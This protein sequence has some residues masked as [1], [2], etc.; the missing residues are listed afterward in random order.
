MTYNP[1]ATAATPQIFQAIDNVTGLP[2][3]GGL[4]YTYAS[5]TLT[6]QA[7]YTDNT[8][9]VPMSNPIVLDNYGQAI[10]W[11]STSPYRFNLINAAGVQQAHYPMD[12]IQPANF[13]SFTTSLAGYANTSQGQGL[14]GFNAA[15]SYPTNT[16]PN[17]LAASTGSSLIGYKSTLSNSVL[18]TQA[19]KDSDWISVLDFGADPTGVTDSTTSIQ[20][21]LN[22]GGNIYVPAG[23]YKVGP[24]TM[25]VAGTT[26][27][28]AGNGITIFNSTKAIPFAITASLTGTQLSVSSASG[29]LVAGMSVQPILTASVQWD[30]T[31]I[32]S[33]TNGGVAPCVATLASSPGNTA[34]ESMGCYPASGAPCIWIQA[35]NCSVRDIQ[36]SFINTPSYI[37]GYIN[38]STP[39]GDCSISVGWGELGMGNNPGSTII[40][41]TIIERCKL[42]SSLLH[43]IAV[44]CSTNTIV[45]NNYILNCLATSII[46]EQSSFIEISGNE[47]TNSRDMSIY[48]EARTGLTA[49]FSTNTMTQQSLPS[50]GAVQVGSRIIGT[51]IPINTIVSSYNSGGT[52]INTVGAIYTLST[53][54]GTIATENIAIINSGIPQGFCQNVRITN[55]TIN[56]GNQGG[57]GLDTTCGFVIANNNI[58][59][60][61][62]A[63]ILINYNHGTAPYSYMAMRGEIINNTIDQSFGNF[64]GTALHASD[65]YTTSGGNLAMI[66]AY[67]ADDDTIGQLVIADNTCNLAVD[68]SNSVSQYYAGILATGRALTISGNVLSGGITANGGG[69]AI[70]AGLTSTLSA[71]DIVVSGNVAKNFYYGCQGVYSTNLTISDN[72]FNTGNTAFNFVSSTNPTV[73][74]NAIVAYST[75]LSSSSTTGI[76]QYP[77]E[78]DNTWIPAFTSY[79]GTI[80]TGSV[81]AK[82]KQYGNTVYFNVYIPGSSVTSSVNSSYFSLPSTPA[83]TGICSATDSINTASYGNGLITTAGKCYTPT[84]GAT[85]AVTVSGFYFLT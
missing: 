56:G 23:T 16:L 38:G 60:T 29:T 47:I 35:N 76:I 7:A 63:P 69:V 12:N 2:L 8:L 31:T 26:L 57:I 59:N 85:S 68:L 75:R 14:V 34:S 71:T 66:T 77:S 32:N 11:L 83:N 54:P 80:T 30:Y 5:G 20:N 24:L 22:N 37:L 67:S 27:E 58:V 40:D 17:S 3:A 50:V 15:L 51:G 21:A 39:T 82:Y 4:L 43:G 41:N 46:G 55:N 42:N 79:G 9:T 52:G 78:I 74:S 48:V 45:R 44:G 19:S 61:W 53:S 73:G 28:G 36:L 70:H 81:V 33:V 62:N 13:N 65:V 49:S 10:F 6:P 64:G 25:A 72:N 84:W 18:R 1:N